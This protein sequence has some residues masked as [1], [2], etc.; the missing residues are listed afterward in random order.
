MIEFN[1]RTKKYN[2][3]L[4]SRFKKDYKKIK[5]QNKDITKLAKVI[6]DLANGKELDK[7]YKNH[8]L[9][10]DKIFKDCYECHI[11]PDWLLVYKIEN[12][13]LILLLFATES[14]SDLFF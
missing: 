9:I 7:A 11:E 6:N 2:I 3:K 8:K 5:K 14:H 10:N 4:T 1:E 12:E 13:E